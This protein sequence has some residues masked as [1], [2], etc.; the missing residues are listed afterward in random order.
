MESLGKERASTENE[1]QRS[2][3][4][5]FDNHSREACESVSEAEIEVE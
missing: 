5:T 4:R 1:E 2:P 3:S